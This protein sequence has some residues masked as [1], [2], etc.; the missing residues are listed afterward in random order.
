MAVD[1]GKN[2][3]TVTLASGISNTDT[4]IALLTGHG[5]RLEN[6]A[7]FGQYNLVL[8]DKT[9]GNSPMTDTNREVVRVTALS[10]DTIT[11]IR[12][13]EG[14]SAVNH[15][16]SGH[17]YVLDWNITAILLDQIRLDYLPLAGGTVTGAAT[18]QSPL[19]LGLSGGTSGSL[20]FIASDNDQANIAI[21]TSDQLVFSGASGGYTFANGNVEIGTTTPGSPL[22]VKS[23]TAEILKLESTSA[24]NSPYIAFYDSSA[25][26]GYFGYGGE[27]SADTISIANEEATGDI[28]I[29]TGGSY[30]MKIKDTG[31]VGI[32]TVDLD[33][34]P[35]I[36]RLVVKG[37]TND[38]S[39]NILVGRDSD[40]VNQFYFDTNGGLITLGSGTFGGSLKAVLAEYAD[41]AAAGTAGLTAGQFY[42]TSAG[43]VMVKL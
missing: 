17:T 33:G 42:K 15:N 43:V 34:T 10:S 27:G 12:A 20:A 18:F 29:S 8:Y 24:S 22:S 38:G 30:R 21:N 14:T 7:T 36:G 26:K 5:A 41:D 35:T 1:K 9:L 32:G 28:L 40:E 25:R 4:N 31:N 6:P 16:T 13:Q 23:A 19:T 37:T 2:F 39:T 3:T 11:V